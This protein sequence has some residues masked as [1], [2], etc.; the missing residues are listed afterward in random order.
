MCQSLIC[1]REENIRGTCI[2]VVVFY[3]VILVWRNTA[4]VLYLYPHPKAFVPISDIHY[5]SSEQKKRGP[6]D[7]LLPT[8]S[9]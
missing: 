6:E 1:K 3:I 8:Q 5:T 9:I 2:K 7:V 4:N